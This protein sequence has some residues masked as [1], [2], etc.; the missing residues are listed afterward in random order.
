LPDAKSHGTQ[1]SGIGR[2]DQRHLPWAAAIPVTRD[3][4]AVN[5]FFGRII[6]F[7][8]GVQIGAD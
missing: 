8:S 3:P 4:F 6:R 2:E 5:F 1:K 7:F